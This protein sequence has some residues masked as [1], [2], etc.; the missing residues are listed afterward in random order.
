M[1]WSNNQTRTST[2]EHKRWAAIVRRN[3]RGLCQLRLAGC[4]GVM[5][6][7]DHIVPVA[8]GGLEL[9]PVNG[10]GACTSCHDIK[11]AAERQRGRAR[12]YSKAQHPIERHPGLR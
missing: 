8:E 9:D 4:T 2:A 10:Q 7:A 11:T 5:Q 3:A 12:H 6:Q 1:P